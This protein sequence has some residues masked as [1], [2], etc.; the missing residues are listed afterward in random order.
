MA[1]NPIDPVKMSV[2][3]AYNLGSRRRRYSLDPAK[4]GSYAVRRSERF[5]RRYGR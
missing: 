2:G 3:K 5:R 1:A 4:A